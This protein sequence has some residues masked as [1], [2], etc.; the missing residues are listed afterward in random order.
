MEKFN[1]GPSYNKNYSTQEVLS[2]L[3]KNWPTKTKINYL[4]KQ[5]LKNST[6]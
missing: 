3:S 2:Y 1:F 6:Y 4:K 5:I